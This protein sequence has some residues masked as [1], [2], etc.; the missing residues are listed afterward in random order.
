METIF[1][2]FLFVGIIKP[3]GDHDGRQMYAYFHDGQVFEH[4]YKEEIIHAM[5]T[6]EF[7]YNEDIK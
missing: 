4:A 5:R 1:Y 2:F 7:V 6:N 3:Q